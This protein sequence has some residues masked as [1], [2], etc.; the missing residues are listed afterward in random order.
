M[1]LTPEEHGVVRRAVAAY[2]LA[3]KGQRGAFR[4][5][6]ADQ[7]LDELSPSPGRWTE[8]AAFVIAVVEGPKRSHEVDAAA[9]FRDS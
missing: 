7:I 3:K 4:G 5:I 6:T 8:L 9:D 1:E 2:R